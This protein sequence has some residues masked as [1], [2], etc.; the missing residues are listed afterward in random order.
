[1]VASSERYKLHSCNRMYQ[2]TEFSCKYN[3]F[4]QRKISVTMK[5]ELPH[6]KQMYLKIKIKIKLLERDI[7]TT[8]IITE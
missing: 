7:E 2:L 1:M 3:K 8:Q 5:G 6:T 4:Y